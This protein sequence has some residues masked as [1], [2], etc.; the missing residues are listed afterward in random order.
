[1]FLRCATYSLPL[2][3]EGDVSTMTSLTSIATFLTEDF[4]DDAERS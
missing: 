4:L 2:Y 1:V 3:R